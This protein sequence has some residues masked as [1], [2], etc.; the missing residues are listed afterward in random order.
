MKNAVLSDEL[1]VAGK[2]VARAVDGWLAAARARI[3]GGLS[4]DAM[5]AAWVD[6]A[7]HMAQSPAHGTAMVA[8]GVRVWRDLAWFAAGQVNPVL[9]K[10]QA[11][12]APDHRFVGPEWERWPYSGAV[13][14][15]LATEQW[16]HDMF[17]GVEGALPHH[18]QLA[19]FAA[20]QALAL[21]APCNVPL[22]N[23]VVTRR[24]AETGGRCLID[25]VMHLGEDV[26]RSANGLPPVGSETQVVG[27]DV[28]TASGRVV[29]RNRLMELIQYDPTTDLVH[30]EPVLIVPA[31]IMKF[32]ILD[33]SPHNS[34]VHW[35]TAQ[36]FTV[37][38]ISW[39]NPGEEEA[40]TGFA[41]YIDMGPRAALDAIETLTGAAK[42]HTAGYCLG[43]TLLAIAAAALA[44]DGDDRLASLSLFTAQTDFSEPGE[45]GLF[46]DDDQV[47]ALDA[48]MA[49]RGYLS[50]GQMA[51]AFKA[52]RSEDLVWAHAVH[53][54]LLGEREVLGD[55]MAWNADG[56]RMPYAMH[57]EYLH[58]LFLENALARGRFHVDDRAVTLSALLVPVFSVGTEKDHVA[59]WRSVFKIHQLTE[60][61]LT[62]VL[63]SGGHN[64]GIV[65]EP[66]HPHRHYRVALREGGASAPDPDE[67]L[68]R[69]EEHAGSWWT[70][71]AGWLAARSGVPTVPPPMGPNLAPAPGTYVLER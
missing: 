35:L 14:S 18:R 39:H 40:G 44:R 21:A 49:R 47:A 20:R 60:A 30:P 61:E 22:A 57:S 59:P 13:Q 6:V 63:A 2:P 29:Y 52:L 42:V 71:W 66:G 26:R 53:T 17:D 5:C 65:S 9:P 43:G 25:G 19:A 48:A 54:Y 1:P 64:A 58:R 15:Y 38:M 46:I 11:P 70:L 7:L 10:T 33:L 16:L 34:M 45:I 56:T 3:A 32:Y 27:R 4:P 41:D 69:A 36:G 55:L 8:Q 68:A 24:I 23:P 51:G 67:W 50:S 12:A 28:A 62:F 37:F 31:W